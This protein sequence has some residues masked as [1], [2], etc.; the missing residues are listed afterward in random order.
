MVTL[1]NC[2]TSV[3]AGFTIFAV[4]GN[5]AATLK[6]EIED[7]AVQGKAYV[8]FLLSINLCGSTMR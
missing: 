2:A 3:F 4:I 1:S 6:L 8:P 5:M 7:V